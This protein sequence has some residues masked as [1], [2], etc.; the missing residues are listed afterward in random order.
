MMR[1]SLE[2]VKQKF[3]NEP[4][5]GC[6]VGVAT[7]VNAFDICSH[8]NISKMYLIDPYVPYLDST[9]LEDHSHQKQAAHSRLGE[10]DSKTVWIENPETMHEMC[11]FIYIDGNH[12]TNAVIADLAQY[13]MLVVDGGVLCGH[14]FSS[15]YLG[16]MI[17]VTFF[18]RQKGSEL[19]VIDDD[20]WIDL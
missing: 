10:F 16:V 7:G 4:L 5:V 15:N 1:P 17:A 12:S 20:W 3:G 18:N 13:E 2:H 9:G 19:H 11:H 6:E 14:D 8:M